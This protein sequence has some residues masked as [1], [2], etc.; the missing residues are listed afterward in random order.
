MT[1]VKLLILSFFDIYFVHLKP[2]KKERCFK[3]DVSI[4]LKK[5]NYR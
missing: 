2:I 4:V 3:T 1:G 5:L